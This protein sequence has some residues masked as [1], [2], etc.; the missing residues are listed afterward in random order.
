MAKAKNNDINRTFIE[1]L[2]IRK[3]IN[4]TMVVNFFSHQK[5]IVDGEGKL[6]VFFKCVKDK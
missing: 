5:K 4:E 2:C 6:L 3:K 1:E